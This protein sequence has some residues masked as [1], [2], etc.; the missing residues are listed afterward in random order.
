MKAILGK[1]IKAVKKT[2]RKIVS[3]GK[4]DFVLLVPANAD[5]YEL[6]AAEEFTELFHSA[7]GITLKTVAEGGEPQKAF[8]ALGNTKTGE[9]VSVPFDEFGESGYKISSLGNSYVLKGGKIGVLYAVYDLLNIL[10]DYQTFAD[11]TVRIRKGVTELDFA[12]IEV[13]EVPDFMYRSPGHAYVKYNERLKNRL[14]MTDLEDILGGEDGPYHNNFNFIPP[15]KFAAKHPDWYSD[16]GGQMCYTAHGNEEERELLEQEAARAIAEYIRKNPDMPYIAFNH[17]DNFDW[18]TCHACTALK[19][20]YEG[21]NSASAAIFLNRVR[22]KLQKW[23]DGEG[24]AFDKGQK[25]VFFAY[26]GTNKPPVHY[27]ESADS[28]SLI[29]PEVTLKGVIPW[30]AETNADYTCPL[31]CGEVNAPVARNLRGWRFLSDEVLFWT[32]GTNFENYLAPY[33]SFGGTAQTYKFAKEN[34]AGLMFDECQI[35]TAASTGWEELK[36]YLGAKLA[37]NTEEDVERLTNEFFD[38]S[39]GAGAEL[40]LKV[41]RDYLSAGAEQTRNGFSGWRSEFID[42]INKKFWQKDRLKSWDNDMTAALEKVKGNKS[43]APYERNIVL[44]RASVRYLLAEVFAD[45]YTPSELKA[46]R[47]AAA[48]DIRASGISMF[49]EKKDISVLFEKWGV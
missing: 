6:T 8:F 49:N 42:P 40:M 18:C 35:N 13:T 27:D 37:W 21:A 46:A 19:E 11:K 5:K 23:F 38:A 41:F 1:H 12:D 34:G 10:L 7:T 15:A 36:G 48:K 47:K 26:H 32:Y 30:F 39:Y 3:G 17:Q 20:K 16:D 22:A 45:E 44:E 9:S 4:T 43:D 14:R 25:L 29:D 24:K 31:Y 2:S 33:Y 28:F